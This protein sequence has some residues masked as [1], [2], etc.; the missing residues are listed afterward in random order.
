MAPGTYNRFEKGRTRPS[1]DKVD[2]ACR[3]LGKSLE[4]IYF[5][6]DVIE[7][8]NSSL[9][10]IRSRE[11]D[12]NA[13]LT[14]NRLEIQNLKEKLESALRLVESLEQTVRTQQTVIDLLGKRIPEND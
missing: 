8:D 12:Y 9:E 4:S 5:G 11:K 10:E 14:A 1:Q 13:I 6:Y 7:G 3:I 2:R